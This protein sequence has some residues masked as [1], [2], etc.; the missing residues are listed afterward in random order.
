MYYDQHR[1]PNPPVVACHKNSA[2]A[3]AHSNILKVCAP[4]PQ[5]FVVVNDNCHPR[6]AE[7]GEATHCV[8]NKHG[9]HGVQMKTLNHT[10][11]RSVTCPR[12]RSFRRNPGF[13]PADTRLCSHQRACWDP[14][15]SS[16]S[17]PCMQS[18]GGVFSAVTSNGIHYIKSFVL[19]QC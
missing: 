4:T 14:G 9:A 11:V 10:G 17:P 12:A 19:S 2:R 6:G 8:P 3:L 1:N 7:G 18:G 13:S 5:L 15:V 16:T